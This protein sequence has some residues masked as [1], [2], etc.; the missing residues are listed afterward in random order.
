MK[1]TTLYAIGRSRSV[2]DDAANFADTRNAFYSR[3]PQLSYALLL[4]KHRWAAVQR[5]NEAPHPLGC[6]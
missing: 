6:R 3:P 2:D 5:V 4:M 1:A